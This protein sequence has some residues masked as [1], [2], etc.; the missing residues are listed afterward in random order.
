MPRCARCDRPPHGEYRIGGEWVVACSEACARAA[1]PVRNVR[2]RIG[3]AL[4]TALIGP[5]QA[6][7]DDDMFAGVPDELIVEI[8]KSY[9]PS[10]LLRVAGTNQRL[11]EIV[12]D[13]RVIAALVDSGG[14]AVEEWLALAR[15]AAS[16]DQLALLEAIVAA[17]DAREKRRGDVTSAE[18]SARR[19]Q[20]TRFALALRTHNVEFA[21]R[22]VGSANAGDVAGLIPHAIRLGLDRGTSVTLH[23]LLAVLRQPS[24]P[25]L[26]VTI[27]RLLSRKDLFASVD[28]FTMLLE[29]GV[30]A[31]EHED[32]EAATATPGMPSF[33]TGDG[34]LADAIRMQRADIVQLLV[35]DGRSK[36]SS[37]LLQIPTSDA[38]VAIL[39]RSRAINPFGAATLAELRAAELRYRDSRAARLMEGADFE[40]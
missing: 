40:W 32:S 31:V 20:T 27:G 22:M 24:M 33:T 23:T 30:W 5:E 2:A 3:R 13:A 37:N 4:D 10:A 39:L 16:T 35:D 25:L 15:R 26:R 7:V 18:Y 29:S 36:L 17:L 1:M 9:P 34:V 19:W 38:V 28:M 12:L 6:T 11:R 21:T 14:A 8:L